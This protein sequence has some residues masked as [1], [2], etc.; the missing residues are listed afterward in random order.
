MTIT[1]KTKMQKYLNYQMRVTLDDGRVVIGT[2]MAFDKHMNLVLGD[3]VEH[4]QIGRGKT[5]REEKRPL[6]LLVLRGESLISLSAE[7]PPMDAN[8]GRQAPAL[9]AGPGMA[10]AV[11][12]GVAVP[13]GAR[14][15]GLAG[16]VAGVGGP[17]PGMLTPQFG[18]MPPPAG[19]GRGGPPMPGMPMPGMPM[20]GM[21]GMPMPGMPP[22]GRGG[23][24]PY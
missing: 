24:P 16:P 5:L 21:P 12:R 18:N 14:P 2:L 15:A 22:M 10:T 7:A 17:A 13:A 9:P 20:P 4:R 23:P 3:A 8:P 1:R 6:G 19:F 11:G